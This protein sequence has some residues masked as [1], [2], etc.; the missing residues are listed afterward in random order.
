MLCWTIIVLAG[1][2]EG[3]KLFKNDV[4]KTEAS[5][6]ETEEEFQE[7]KQWKM[8][9]LVTDCSICGVKLKKLKDL[10]KKLADILDVRLQVSVKT[11]NGYINVYINHNL[12]DDDFPE[13]AGVEKF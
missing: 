12:D 8:D 13:P 7:R 10:Q 1:K 9:T 5:E 4:F 6:Y 3:K 11:K 2:H